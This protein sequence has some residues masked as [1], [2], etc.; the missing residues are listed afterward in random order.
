MTAKALWRRKNERTDELCSRERERGE[1]RER[2]AGYRD[3]LDPTH[4]CPGWKMERHVVGHWRI[5]SACTNPWSTHRRASGYRA[6]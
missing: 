1:E 4:A 5:G 3:S 2:E 6:A